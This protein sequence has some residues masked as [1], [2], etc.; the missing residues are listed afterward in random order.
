MPRQL[1][2]MLARIRAMPMNAT[3]MY[4]FHYVMAVV[5][6]G[7]MWPT[8][9]SWK[10]SILWVGLISCY[11]NFA[12]HWGAGAAYESKVVAGRAEQ[13]SIEAVEIVRQGAVQDT[14]MLKHIEKTVVGCDK[15]P[16]DC[17]CDSV[18]A[19]VL[20]QREEMTGE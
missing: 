10:T 16:G 17:A 15:W 13:A 3:I 6:L 20:R 14:A 9:T 7:L 11:A 2:L 12:T 8:T 5:W 1:K 19:C 18:D 4:R